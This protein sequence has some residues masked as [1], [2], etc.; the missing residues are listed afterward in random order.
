MTHLIDCRPRND[1]ARAFFIFDNLQTRHDATVS[2]VYQTL[3]SMNISLEPRQERFVTSLQSRVSSQLSN[4]AAGN[5][6]RRRAKAQTPNERRNI[7]N[8][9]AN[10]QI[11]SD[12]HTHGRSPKPSSRLFSPFTSANSNTKSTY[13]RGSSSGNAA[14]GQP[15]TTT[16]SFFDRSL[17]FGPKATGASDSETRAQSFHTLTQTHHL[18]GLPVDLKSG[19]G[20]DSPRAVWG[21]FGGSGSI[22]SGQS[23]LRKDHKVQARFA[24]TSEKPAWL[25]PSPPPSRS[26]TPKFTFARKE[27]SATTTPINLRS[28]NAG[29]DSRNLVSTSSGNSRQEGTYKGGKTFE[30]RSESKSSLFDFAEMVKEREPLQPT[31]NPSQPSPSPFDKA[32]SENAAAL[33]ENL[34]P[35][36]GGSSSTA[37]SSGN[38]AAKP[39][40]QL[41]GLREK[42]IM[43]LTGSSPEFGKTSPLRN[44]LH[45]QKP[46]SNDHVFNMPKPGQPRPEHHRP[47]PQPPASVWPPRAPAAFEPTHPAAPGFRMPPGYQSQYVPDV[48]EVPKPTDCAAP[49]IQAQSRPM[50]SSM[51]PPSGFASV[52]PFNAPRSTV[53]LTGDDDDAFDPD[54]AL[55]N[56]KFGETDP[57]MYVDHEQSN[58]N[59]KA[60]LEGAF[61][62]EDDKPK[63][64]LRKRKQPEVKQESGAKGLAGKLAA[65]DVKEEDGKDDKDEEEEIDDGTIDGLKCKLLPH[66]VD[67]LAW[68]TDKEIGKRKKN[69]MLPKGGILADDV[70]FPVPEIR[71][72]VLILN[73]WV[74][75]RPSSPLLSY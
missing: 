30:E 48:F 59:M 57:F 40:S 15:N 33:M 72:F 54:A 18:F 62:D 69:G 75:E 63:L 2:V 52:Q 5:S 29:I 20:S 24:N 32:F 3:L 56:M 14:S 23:T 36:S 38:S 42:Q 16:D 17:V 10:V 22:V 50:F 34:A 26:Q 12:Y 55:R 49:Q 25:T 46:R 1:D 35:L 21:L 45:N 68:M 19:G 58:K 53:D 9:F 11:E 71:F 61:E 8:L 37:S 65:L 67:G 47:R 60:L 39:E 31:Q 51:N 27:S 6:S 44:P 43:D 28:W 70:R 64:R 66:Q 74:L 4:M 7:S 13:T 41:S 73:R